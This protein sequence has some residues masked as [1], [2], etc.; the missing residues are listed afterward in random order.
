MWRKIVRGLRK[1]VRKLPV[2]SGEIGKALAEDSDSRPEEVI[3]SPRFP[4]SSLDGNEVGTKV[5]GGGRSR[6]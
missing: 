5:G 3:S 1:R 2:F 6:T 4:V